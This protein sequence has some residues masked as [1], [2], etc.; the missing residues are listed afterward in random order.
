M[1]TINA[2]GNDLTGATGT[3]NFVGSTSPTLVTPALG[4]PSSGNLVNCTGYPGIA[5]WAANS[6]ASIS[7]AI[8]NGYILTSA[9][10]TTVTLP[11][12]FAVGS[13]I[14]VA[15]QGAAWTLALGAA[16]NVIAFGTTYS[17]SF[18]SVNNSDALVLVAVVANTTWSILYLSSKGLTAS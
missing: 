5:N 15:G 14:G 3:G 9:S 18:A 7:A 17:T 16:T 2:V 4:T 11:T 6:N 8:N 1:T 12:T 10:P 13:V